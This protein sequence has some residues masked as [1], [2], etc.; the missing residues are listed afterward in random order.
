M[1]AKLLITAIILTF[2]SS[3]YGQ[4]PTFK[5]ENST[6]IE[7][8]KYQEA[9]KWQ[10]IDKDLNKL[11]NKKVDLE[12]KKNKKEEKEKSVSKIDKI[13]KINEKIKVID[14]KIDRKLL[15]NG[16]TRINRGGSIKFVKITDEIIEYKSRENVKVEAEKKIAD[17]LIGESVDTSKVDDAKK[18]LKIINDAE[19]D[20]QT[21]YDQYVATI[22]ESKPNFYFLPGRTNAKN[23]ISFLYDGEDKTFTPFVGGG[24]SLGNN[25]GALYSEF[26]SA[27]LRIL[28]VSFGM[29]VSSSSSSGTE[30]SK[31]A[32][33]YQRLISYGGN[34]VLNIEY[35]ALAWYASNKQEVLVASII[36][37]GTCDLPALGTTTNNWAGSGSLGLNVYGDLATDENEMRFFLNFNYRGIIGTDSFLENLGVD[38][39]HITLGQLEVGIVIF[40]N[41]KVSFTVFRFSNDEA[42][43]ISKATVGAQVVK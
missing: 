36:G 42:L 41:V 5:I 30:G 24:F 17:I 11:Q 7:L 34:T 2:M 25:T 16:L 23:I 31:E 26:L 13:K 27:N 15:D 1:K 6:G 18:L 43:R 40:K 4:V 35:P 10:K 39:K 20:Q 14:G 28:R 21:F 37:K 3:L 12:A 9:R 22:K 8:K 38:R 19:V 32:E 33:A 29:M